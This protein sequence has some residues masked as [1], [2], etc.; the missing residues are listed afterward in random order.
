MYPSASG[1]GLWRFIRCGEITGKASS[2]VAPCVPPCL[3]DTWTNIPLH[4]KRGKV[5]QAL[6]V[7]SHGTDTTVF[8]PRG[9]TCLCKWGTGFVI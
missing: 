7:L 3:W 4:K 5:S 2:D 8:I 9:P 1:F 6:I